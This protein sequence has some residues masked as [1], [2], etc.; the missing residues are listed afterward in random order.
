LFVV[1]RQYGE[2]HGFGTSAVMGQTM[3]KPAQR[4]AMGKLATS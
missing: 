1:K 2:R 3:L 4:V